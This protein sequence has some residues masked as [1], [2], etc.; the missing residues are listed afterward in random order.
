MSSSTRT[1]NPSAAVRARGDALQGQIH[2]AFGSVVGPGEQGQLPVRAGT[3]A[4]KQW[5]NA[6][7]PGVFSSI[8]AARYPASRR[9][10]YDDAN[11]QHRDLHEEGRALDCMTTDPDTLER[12]A[13]AFVWH[14]D[15][16]GLQY[17]LTEHYEWSS[18]HLGAAWEAYSGSDPHT[19]HIHVELSPDVAD[20]AARVVAGLDAAWA[21]GW[22]APGTTTTA[23]SSSSRAA[24]WIGGAVAGVAGF[25]A[26]ITR[27]PR[28]T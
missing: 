2:H 20:D 11:P 9:H 1:W 25:L 24:W 19:D 28:Q 7:F 3:A 6:H 27:C 23:T 12:F 18:S 10:V 22:D 5:L 8:G 13:S 16:I 17:V 26:W 4:M 14:A 15:V 21:A